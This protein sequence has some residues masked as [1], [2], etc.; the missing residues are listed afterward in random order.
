MRKS[1]AS[2]PSRREYAGVL[3]PF[4]LSTMTQPLIGAVD[5]AVMGRLSDP[6]YIAGVAVGAVIFNTI[7]WLLGFLRVGSTGF[8]AQALATGVPEE[9]WKALVLPGL[10]ALALGGA[11]LLLQGPLFAGAMLILKLD[12]PTRAVAAAY[13]RIL[14]WAAPVVLLNYVI[15]G[16]LMGQTR[17]R[18]SLI[19]QIGGNVVNAVL[20]L[21]FVLGLGWDVAGVAAASILACLFSFGVGLMALRSG[22]PTRHSPVRSLVRLQEVTRILRVNGNLF[23]R[24]VCLLIQTNIF[25]ATTATFGTV[26]LS[27]N[28]II[29]QIMLIF[30]YVFEGIANASSV[31]A[32]RAA[33]SRNASMLDRIRRFT[34]EGSLIAAG[35]MTLIYGCWQLQLLRLFTNLPEVL[36]AASAYSVWGLF[37]PAA[38]ALGVTYYGIFTGASFTRPVFCSTLQALAVFLFCWL[39]AVPRLGN[40]G[41]WLA[42]ICFYLGRSVFL[43]R[44]WPA[45]QRA[46]APPPAFELDGGA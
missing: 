42:Y 22:F 16:W 21:L 41:L 38:A 35:I 31:F 5:T 2:A 20:D 46:A 8:S 30:T 1:T 15:L 23:L 45:V 43:L 28:A 24:T 18:S 17:I 19:M 10:M 39:I 3:L 25:M 27:A 12:P 40:H 37:F 33:G 32:G 4:I 34:L 9:S 7:Y 13:Y 6:A 26:Q 44:Y 29:I 11:I 14:V 36:K